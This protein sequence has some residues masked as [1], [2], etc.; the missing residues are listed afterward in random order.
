MNKEKLSATI[1]LRQ[2]QPMTERECQMFETYRSYRID[3]LNALEII[4][5]ARRIKE[6]IKDQHFNLMF[7]K[8][9]EGVV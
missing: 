5:N 6:S 2:L 3:V 4:A 8:F 7:H 1:L 9:I